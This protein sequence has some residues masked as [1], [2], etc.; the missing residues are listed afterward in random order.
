M[1]SDQWEALSSLLS[2]YYFLFANVRHGLLH[3]LLE[4]YSLYSELSIHLFMITTLF[5]YESRCGWVS[6]DLILFSIQARTV[7]PQ[8]IWAFMC[9]F[10]SVCVCLHLYYCVCVPVYYI[11]LPTCSP[12]PKHKTSY[13]K[14]PL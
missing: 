10:L 11:Y 3:H 1:K 5:F 6:K 7:H 9:V 14:E 12:T 2:N 8:V 13:A 4:T